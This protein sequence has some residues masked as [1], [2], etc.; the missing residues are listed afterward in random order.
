MSNDLS[1][2]S[3]DALAY[4]ENSQP[5][6]PSF[7]DAQSQYAARTTRRPQYGYQHKL[8]ATGGGAWLKDPQK[9]VAATEFVA[10][11][12]D[13]MKWIGH[14]DQRD[15]SFAKSLAAYFQRNGFLS[16]GQIKAVRK[17]LPQPVAFVADP[18]QAYIASQGDNPATL[19]MEEADLLAVDL[20]NV[21]SG[22][23]AD[24]LTFE[25]TR[26]KVRID[27]LVLDAEEAGK[28]RGWIFVKDGAEYGHG[29]RYGKQRP[30]GMYEGDIKDTLRAIAVDPGAASRAYGK[31]VGRCGVC[32]R[33]LEDEDSVARGIGPICA[34]KMGW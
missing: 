25:K 29:K 24:P 33:K 13:V 32:G 22:M 3:P 9:V 23:Y 21:P 17:N 18:E 15:N 14:A 34:G 30:G 6:R 20:R 31:L 4:L 16:E 5:A 28:W 27:N 10:Q 11:H 26:L 7:L 19:A 8:Q 2:L 1:H 12:V